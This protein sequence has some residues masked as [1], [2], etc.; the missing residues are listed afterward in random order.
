MKHALEDVGFWY[1]YKEHRPEEKIVL[2]LLYDMQGRKFARL[3]S[4][5]A[6]AEREKAFILA[7][8][9]EVEDSLLEAKTRLAASVSRLRIGG[10]ALTLGEIFR[11]TLVFQ[12]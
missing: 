12:L 8:L 4:K 1:H 5:S 3:G 6:I 10:S 7:G 9:K 2:L 11:L